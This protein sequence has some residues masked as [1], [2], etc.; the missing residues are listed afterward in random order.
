MTTKLNMSNINQEEVSVWNDMK[1]ALNAH[2]SYFVRQPFY[3]HNMDSW[4]KEHKDLEHK[5]HEKLKNMISMRVKLE[6]EAAQT[7]VMM[8]EREDKTVKRIAQKEKAAITQ[9]V[10]RRSSRISLRC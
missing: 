4:E 2:N 3:P 9:V 7:L 5:Y 1:L 10:P 6:I 8:K